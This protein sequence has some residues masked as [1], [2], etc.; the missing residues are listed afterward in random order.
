MGGKIGMKIKLIEQ[1]R[2]SVRVVLTRPDLSGS[3]FPDCEVEEDGASHSRWGPNYTGECTVC[4]PVRGRGHTL[5]SVT[6]CQ[7]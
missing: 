6:I 5:G 3:L 7:H 2:L 4:E 1:S